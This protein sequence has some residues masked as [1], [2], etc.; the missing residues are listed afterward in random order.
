ML[1][2]LLLLLILVLY[3]LVLLLLVSYTFKEMLNKISPIYFKANI[4]KYKN[5]DLGKYFLIK[6]NNLNLYS[7]FSNIKLLL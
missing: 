4:I 3:I 5:S 6:Y 7:F 1:L 2:S